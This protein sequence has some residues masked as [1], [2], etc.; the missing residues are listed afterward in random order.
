MPQWAC[1]SGLR[2]SKT[3]QIA[4]CGQLRARRCDVPARQNQ[5]HSS[6][7]WQ[8]VVLVHLPRGK[9]SASVCATAVLALHPALALHQALVQCTTSKNKNWL[10]GTI[11]INRRLSIRLY[12][13]LPGYRTINSRLPS[14]HN[15]VLDYILHMVGTSTQMFIIDK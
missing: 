13:M 6:Q 3:A 9:R 15:V 4:A 7:D 2:G 12:C 8:A 14:I 10:V 1:H 5:R 11:D